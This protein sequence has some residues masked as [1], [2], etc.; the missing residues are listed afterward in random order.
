MEIFTNK[1]S[2]MMAMYAAKLISMFPEN[3]QKFAYKFVRKLVLA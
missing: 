2:Y 3:D 1:G